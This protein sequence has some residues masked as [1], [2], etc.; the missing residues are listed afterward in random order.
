VDKLN[1]SAPDLI[2]GAAA[3]AAALAA[4]RLVQGQPPAGGLAE[5]AMVGAL[6]VLLFPVAK[7]LVGKTPL[8]KVAL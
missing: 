8:A 1:T 3:G 4:V 7:D 5:G 6:V 2:A